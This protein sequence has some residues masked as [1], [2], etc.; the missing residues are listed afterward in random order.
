MSNRLWAE[1]VK[2]PS[3]WK[4][5]PLWFKVILLGSLLVGGV[6]GVVQVAILIGGHVTIINPGLSF[7]PSPPSLDI[8]TSLLIPVCSPQPC[9]IAPITYQLGIPWTLKNTGTLDLYLSYST[10]LPSG[11]TLILTGAGNVNLQGATLVHGTSTN[12]DMEMIVDS[13]AIAGNNIAF[14]LTVKGCYPLGPC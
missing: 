5:L 6:Y 1:H 3:F 2:K 10:S 11:L 13:T 4:R 12:G 8:S 7:D 9:T 14:T